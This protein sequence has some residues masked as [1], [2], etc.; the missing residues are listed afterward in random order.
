MEEI[1]K[2][3]KNYPKYEV[4]SYGEVR[5]IKRK[6]IISPTYD[7]R[8]DDIKV[9]ICN[10]HGRYESVSLK[11]LIA[12]TFNSG[13]HDDCNVVQIDGDFYNLHTDNLAWVKKNRIV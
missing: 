3:I 4:S 13:P 2:R 6:H 9:F 10:K 5:N 8:D 1:W 7:R 12:E 11:R